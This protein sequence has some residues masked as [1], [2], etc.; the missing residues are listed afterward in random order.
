M[1]N[2]DITK[3][4]SY[5]KNGKE[6]TIRCEGKGKYE[7]CHI[8]GYRYMLEIDI[9]PFAESKTLACIMMN[10]STTF[11]DKEWG[12]NWEKVLGFIEH[13]K[14]PRRTVGFDPTINNVLKMAASK[15]YS[16]VCIFNLFPYIHPT[17]KAAIRMYKYKQKENQDTVKKWKDFNCKKI[18]VA[19]GKHLPEQSEIENYKKLQKKYIK[20]FEK[21]GIKPVFYAW[22]KNAG[23]PYHPSLQVDS[24][25]TYRNCEIVKRKKNDGSL[26]II[27][28]FIDG[29][30]DFTI[31]QNFPDNK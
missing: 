31:W 25:W 23:C 22:N 7:G 6:Y 27:Q 29:T 26:G 18:L 20:L 13:H 21:K 17:G 14:T 5:T 28:Q 3:I 12:N 4:I 30:E 19:W 2:K 1:K 24:C 9:R 15:G 8:G 11:P 10:P 16:K